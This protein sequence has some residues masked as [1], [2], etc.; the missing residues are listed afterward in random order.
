MKKFMFSLMAVAAMA[1]CSKGPQDFTDPNLAPEESGAP[2]AVL[3][4]T[5]VKASVVAKSQGGVD[6]WNGAQHLHIL[7]IR[8]QSSANPDYTNQEAVLIDNVTAVSPVEGQGSNSIG[9]FKPGT[10]ESFYYEGNYTYDFFGYYID[11]LNIII[12]KEAKGVYVPIE[13]TGGQDVMLAKANTVED[14][15]K[16]KEAGDFTGDENF[17]HRYAYSAYAARR[18]VH[19]SLNFEHQLVRFRFY[20]ESG[21]DFEEGGN[22]ALVVKS[23][24]V[25]SKYRA[26]LCVAGTERG[27]ANIVDETKDLALCS[28]D[29]E[30]KELVDLVPYLVHDKDAELEEDANLLGESLMVF[31]GEQEY[32][33]N[34][35]L[36]QFGND[37]PLALNL[38]FSD[39]KEGM[40]NQTA[41]EAGYSYKVY[42]KVVGLEDVELTAEL[43]E[44]KDGGRVEIDSDDAP[45]VIE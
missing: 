36:N 1:A 6:A 11:D 21:S 12:R 16:S 27:L 7:G 3:L 15:A 24:S 8:R 23:L 40:Q 4:S 43:E 25:T 9:V 28:L 44:W 13:I 30:T 38:K 37:N 29:S 14:L 42:I 41:F 2:E 20:I 35:V 33:I 45:E 10:E 22:D 18:G 26:E 19:P 17:D 39:V 31:P 5:N 34:L 32:K